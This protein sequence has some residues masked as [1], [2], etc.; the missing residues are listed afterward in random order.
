M[1][2]ILQILPAVGVY[3]TLYAS[4]IMTKIALLACDNPE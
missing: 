4:D 2:A 1:F 3:V